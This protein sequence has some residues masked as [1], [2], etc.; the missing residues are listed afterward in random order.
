[1]SVMRG[2]AWAA[3][4]AAGMVTV[5]VLP[6]AGGTAGPAA[7]SPAVIVGNSDLTG[8]FCASGRDCW[9]VGF[10]EI[11]DVVRN[12]A[13]HFTGSR[14]SSV[15]TPNPGGT[16]FDDHSQL[17]GVR[18]PSAADCWAVGTYVKDGA[19]LTQALHWNGRK[20][21]LVPTPDPGGTGNGDISNL[22]DVACTSAVNCWAD[23][24]YGNA[25]G[26]TGALLNLMLHWN[27]T[28]WSQVRTPNPGGTKHGG[29]NALSAT[30]C[31][32]VTDCWGVGAD[33]MDATGVTI[34]NEVLHWNGRHWRTVT[35]PSPGPG[36]ELVSLSCTS[37]RSCWAVGVDRPNQ[38]ANEALHWNGSKWRTARVPNPASGGDAFAGLAGV[39]CTADTNCWAVGE[40]RKPTGSGV[41]RNEMLHWNGHTWSLVAVPEP[42]GTAA[43]S[44]NDLL[45]DHCVSA[46]NCWAV[47]YTQKFAEPEVNQILHWTGK[48]WRVA[49]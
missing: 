41:I 15:A 14:W 40:F 34:G 48:K 7:A 43:E 12:Q 33:G 24:N 32:S 8:V 31:T 21:S 9:A 13:L 26:F 47:G 6:V 16:A 42:A 29:V 1:M 20:W 19:V 46:T 18:C 4:V 37:A 23:G 28:K 36:S 39:S 10:D 45:A 49:G 17:A 25:P 2:R 35:A 44:V 38:F 5:A 3:G 30:R 27:G 11:N 22:A